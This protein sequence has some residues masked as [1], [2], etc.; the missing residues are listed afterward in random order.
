MILTNTYF[1]VYE[2]LEAGEIEKLRSKLGHFYAHV[3]RLLN[4]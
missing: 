3:H 4:D 2:Y 1:I